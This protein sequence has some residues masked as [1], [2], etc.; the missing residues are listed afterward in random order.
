MLP[1]LKA[2]GLAASLPAV[3]HLKALVLVA[4]MLAAC[5]ST[6]FADSDGDGLSDEQELA[7]G[8]DPENPDTDGDGLADGVDPDPTGSMQA[9]DI[10]LLVDVSTPTR[11]GTE[12]SCVVT[13]TLSDP[14]GASILADEVTA[15]ATAGTLTP[16]AATGSVYSASLTSAT[17]GKSVVT[18]SA[19]TEGCGTITR[20]ESVFFVDELPRPGNNTPPYDGEGGIDGH[21]WVYTVDGD[22]AADPGSPVLPEE[23]V[24]VIVERTHGPAHRV[25]KTSDA[26]GVVEFQEEGLA[27]PVNVTVA[28]A[29]HKAFTMVAVNAAHVSLPL[30]PL[31]PVPGVEDELTGSVE[32]IVTGFAGES[33]VTRFEPLAGSIDTMNIGIV[34]PGL[35]NVQLASLSMGSVLAYGTEPPTSFPPK[36]PNMIIPDAEFSADSCH[37]RMEG[38]APGPQLIAVV[39]GIG[40]NV[41]KTIEDPYAMQFTP[42]AMG[43]AVVEVKAD[44]TVQLNLPLEIDFVAQAQQGTGVFDVLLGHFPEDP[45]TGAPFVNSLLMPVMDTAAFGFLWTDI[46]GAYNVLGPGANPLSITYPDPAAAVF[47][48]WGLDLFFM[49]VALAGRASFLGA[50]PPGISTV[51]VREQ[52]WGQTLDASRDYLWLRVPEGVTPAPP[53]P[54]P[55]KPCVPLSAIPDPP[56]S[57]VG[58]KDPPTHYLPLDRVGG[59]LADGLIAWK[60]VAKPRAA[61]LYAVRLGYLVTAP[62]NPLLPGYSI[63]GPDSYKLWEVVVPGSVTGIT[64]PEL[65]ES[66]YGPAGLLR[67]PAPNVGDPGAAQQYAADTLELEL[68]AYLMGER[69]PFDYHKNFPLADMNLNSGAVSQDSYPV[70]VPQAR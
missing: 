64:L 7:F 13:L 40:K 61:D 30:T 31:D 17:E 45:F 65:P 59:T 15:K 53:D 35:K 29:G 48:K 57:C 46:N 54:T 34:Q 19:T 23:G 4:S 12:W 3:C 56:G 47:D 55:A 25:E 28:K 26:T 44:Q 66:V 2:P 63:G 22:S 27:G 5:G 21:L 1:R 14:D 49:T 58:V 16:F 9:C 24:L 41:S 70:T 18:V 69:H 10:S 33:G 11:I 20:Q 62:R 50:D 52:E 36:P 8:T 42:R 39:A 51:I 37:Y 38:L 6:G 60:P 43:L 32:G 67:N 68:S